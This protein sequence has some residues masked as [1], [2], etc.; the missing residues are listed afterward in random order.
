MNKINRED[1]KMI[2]VERPHA[3]YRFFA[4]D[5]ELLYVGI[6]SNPARRFAQ[7]GS[8]KEWWEEVAEIRME[9]LPSREAVL[10]AERAAIIAER[11]RYNVVHANGASAP[12]SLA[13]T[14]KAPAGYPLTAGEVVALGLAPDHH[15]KAGCPVGL[16]EEVGPLG[17][18]LALL[19][20]LS[21]VFGTPRFVTWGRI[22]EI[23]WA[24]AMDPWDA[25]EQ[26]YREGEDIW[27]CDALGDFQTEWV[28]GP[29]ALKEKRQRDQEM[30]QRRAE[31]GPTKRDV[32][33]IF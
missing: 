7:H 4:E 1:K 32:K 3:L 9:R 18:K 17:V 25:R 31:R 6:T 27:D 20:W 11:P 14:V 26:G 29:E 16:V 10:A 2:K 8:D 5:G 33:E 15:G 28:D 30:R 24:F 22:M 21:G 13:E 23:R 12:D 19:S